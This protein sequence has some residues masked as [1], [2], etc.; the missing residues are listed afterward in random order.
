MIHDTLLPCRN[1]ALLIRLS[2]AFQRW[3][4]GLREA[5]GTLLKKQYLLKGVLFKV[6]QIDGWE[7]VGQTGPN[8]RFRMCVRETLKALCSNWLLEPGCL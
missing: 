4:I 5:E 2:R 8:Y 3:A 1:V 6:E 7:E